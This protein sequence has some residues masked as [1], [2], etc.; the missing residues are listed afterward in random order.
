MPQCC[1]PDSRLTSYSGDTLTLLGKMKLRCRF[2]DR[3]TQA[4]F[5]IVDQKKAPA[6]INLETAHKLGL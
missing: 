4:T 6:L 1:P 3:S 2:E 5:Y